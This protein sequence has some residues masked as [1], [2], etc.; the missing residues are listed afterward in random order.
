MA[1]SRETRWRWYGGICLGVSVA[2]LVL[3]MTVLKNRLRPQAFLYYWLVCM[4][5][6]GLALIIAL[7]D[8][9]AVRLRLRREQMDL[10]QRTLLEIEREKKEKAAKTESS[11]PE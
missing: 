11:A 4:L 7:L 3:G 5:V 9:R 6:T 10:M 2:M 8:L 1:L